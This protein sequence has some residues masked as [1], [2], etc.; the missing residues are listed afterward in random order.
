MSLPL[1]AGQWNLDPVHSNVG[2]AVRHSVSPPS[3]AVSARLKPH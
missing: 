3:T 2:F 1:S